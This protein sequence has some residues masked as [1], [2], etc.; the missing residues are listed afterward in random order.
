[1]AE[2]RPDIK[3]SLMLAKEFGLRLEE[4]ATL[5][6][7]QIPKTADDCLSIKGKGGR[8][9]DIPLSKHQF[10]IL[11]TIKSYGLSISR[12]PGDKIIP[13]DL[14]KGSV[15]RTKDAIVHWIANHRHKFMER[16]IDKF[17]EFQARAEANG[18]KLKTE[19]LSLHGLR[20]LF[21]QENYKVLVT[22]GVNPHVARLR[23]SEGLGHHRIGVTA[24][25]MPER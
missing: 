7:N 11:Q 14:N 19:T 6:M 17:K 9:R 12:G 20:Y 2:S 4:I 3:C 5:R 16:D 10:Q 23:C 15:K 22:S 24:I 18:Y 1:M 25:Y 8:W 21:C 13:R